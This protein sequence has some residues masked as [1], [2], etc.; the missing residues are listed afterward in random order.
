M[1]IALEGIAGR[2]DGIFF[3][4]FTRL[5]GKTIGN[6]TFFVIVLQARDSGG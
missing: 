1:I 6:D 5:T 4:I 2:S 3:H